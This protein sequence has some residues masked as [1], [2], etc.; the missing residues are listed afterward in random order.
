MFVTHTR[1]TY[2]YL[3]FRCT[4]CT[5]G[6]VT[7]SAL[8]RVIRTDMLPVTTFDEMVLTDFLMTNITG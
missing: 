2:P 1:I 8:C 3:A 7:D 5:N 6:Y 4:L